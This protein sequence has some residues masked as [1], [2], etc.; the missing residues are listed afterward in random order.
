[1]PSSRPTHFVEKDSVPLQFVGARPH[2]GNF[3]GDP[4][5]KSRLS[6][7]MSRTCIFFSLSSFFW[8]WLFLFLSSTLLFCWKSLHI[9]GSL[10]SKLPWLY[11]YIYGDLTIAFIAWLPGWLF[12]WLLLLSLTC[13]PSWFAAGSCRWVLIR[14]FG[15]DY[16]HMEGIKLDANLWS[17]WSD[18]PIFSPIESCVV[19]V[20]VIDSRPW[21]LYHSI[22]RRFLR[23]D[24]WVPTSDLYGY[25]TP[26]H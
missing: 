11:M 24:G 16:P 6:E 17:F 3:K 4:H 26:F 10:T 19:G 13:Q 5:L 9:V 7:N 15:S 22:A 25:Y 2:Q 1:M 20:G 14:G 21:I 8:F 18:F 23:G 12:G